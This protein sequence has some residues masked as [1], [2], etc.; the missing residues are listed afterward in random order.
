MTHELKCWPSQFHALRSGQK[1]HEVRRVT[2]RQFLD[3]D[4]LLLC[5]WNP[6]TEMYTGERLLVVV[7]H[8][9]LPGTF[10]LPSDVCVMSVRRERRML[11]R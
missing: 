7:T 6:D 8:V 9:T 5:E 1:T 11:A 10:G 4:H 2:D 3:G